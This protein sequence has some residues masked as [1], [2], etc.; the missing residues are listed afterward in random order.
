MTPPHASWI[1][2]DCVNYLGSTSRAT[3]IRLTLLG[4]ATTASRD[5][6]LKLTPKFPASRFLDSRR[7]RQKVIGI[8]LIGVCPPHASWIRDDC[9][10]RRPASSLASS[11]RLTLLGF[12]TTASSTIQNNEDH[13]D[14][15][16]RFLDSR[17]LRPLPHWTG[18]GRLVRLTLLGFA[19]T[20]STR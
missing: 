16:S 9:V 4:F 1:R 19:T 12:A 17:R 20:A 14:P 5:S 18:S 3:T 8:E 13:P 15:A 10:C 7:L 11:S 2:D 6:K